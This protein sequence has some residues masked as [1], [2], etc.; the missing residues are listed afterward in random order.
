MENK[1]IDLSIVT[2]T[3][4]DADNLR[5]TIDSVRKIKSNKI[6]FI[7]ID[8]GSKD[9]TIEIAKLND[10]VIDQFV[11]EPDK[12][13]FDAMNKGIAKATGKWVLF[14][15]AG[16]LIYDTAE[17]NKLDFNK[18]ASFALLYGNTNYANVGV[19]KPFSLTS[20]RYG[21]IMACHQAMIYN[22]ELLGSELYYASD[23][24][25]INDYDLTCRII[26][27]GFEIKY[28]DVTI[29]T[30]LGDGISSKVNWEARKARYSYVFRHFGVRGL[31]TTLG[32][33]LGIL[34]L[35]NRIG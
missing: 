26:D 11:S 6:E 21:L 33:S 19:R 24:K 10:N 4:N 17:F 32:E 30:F 1:E 23:F 8:G 7:V 28:V 34:S 16:D 31:I 14:I 5:L 27:K 3:Y 22:R 2:V 35:P 20:L 9:D 18:Y 12:G 29:A 13:T 25:L 15:N